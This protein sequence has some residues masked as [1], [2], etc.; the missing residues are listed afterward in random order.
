[1][2]YD[3][4]NRILLDALPFK[5]IVNF[6]VQLLFE[7]SKKH[8][9]TLMSDHKL[10]N[11]I[12]DHKLSQILD[13]TKYTSCE[14]YDE[15]KLIKH[16]KNN[17]NLNIFSM[18]I[19]S[20]PLH[21]GELVNYINILQTE[22]HVIVLT[23]IGAKNLSLV[24]NLFTSHHALQY[25][26]PLDN[27]RGGVGIFISSS[28]NDFEVLQNIKLTKN[29][30]CAE[31]QFESLFIDFEF[32]GHKYTVAGVYRHPKGNTTHFSIALEEAV[33]KCDNRRTT[34][35][36]ADSNIDL[37]KFN[38]SHVE[39][40]LTMMLNNK[41]LPYITLP[42]R[43]TE[44]S[45]T[46]IDHIFVRN[47]CDTVK[48]QLFLNMDSGLL[49]C[50]ISDHLPCFLSL[51]LK[52][53]KES[54][55]RPKVR[56]YGIK[57]TENFKNLMKDCNWNA[58]YENSSNWYDDFFKRI[59]S[60]HEKAFPLT[61]LSRKRSHDK[62]WV[63]RGLKISIT[64][65][66]RLYKKQL[67]SNS[68]SIVSKYKKYN[69]LLRKTLRNAET[70]YY[71]QLFEDK[72]S[73][74]T[75]TWKVLGP[76]INPSKYKKKIAIN[77]MKDNGKFFTE[78][79]E[80]VEIINQ[81]FCNIGKNLQQKIPSQNGISYRDYLPDHILNSF[82][83]QPLR[84]EDILLEIAKLNPKK[85]SGPDN[86]G[87][88]ILQ[89]CP[90]VFSYNLSIIFNH[91]IE[92]GEYPSALKLA[93]VIPIYK[94]GDHALPSNYRP[95]SLL[96]VFNKLFERM[97][98]R[99][100]LCFLER[101]EL[102]YCY[103][104]GYRKLHSTTLALIELT[105]SIRRLIDEKNIVFSLFIDFTKAF[106]TVDHQILLDKLTHY[107]V[108]GHT[109][110]FFKSYL[111]NRTQ[112]T[113][114]NG[115]TS[116]IQ[117]VTCGVPQGSVLGPILFLVYVNDLHRCLGNTM[118]RMFADDTNLTL[119]HERSDYLKEMSL[120]KI[121]ALMKWCECNKL[122]INWDKT[123]YI[124]FHAKN[125]KIGSYFNE[126]NVSGNTVKRVSCVKYLGIYID[127]L[128]TWRDHVS[129]VHKSLIRYYGIF[130][131][132]KNFIN[133]KVIRQLYFALV[134]SKIKYGIEL[135]GSCS[136][137]Q[138]HRIQ[139]I[140]S[141]LLKIILNLHRRTGTNQLHLNLRLLKVEHIYKMQLLLFINRCMLGKST[142]LFNSYFGY[143]D[144]QYRLRSRNLNPD[145]ARLQ[146][147]YLSVKNIASREWN[148]ISPSLKNKSNQLNFKKHIASYFISQ[149]G[150]T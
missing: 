72:Q 51:K 112:Y 76:L 145:F 17:V 122:T 132:I 91:Y 19:R 20:L 60:F 136:K 127:E 134:Y 103:Q 57:N 24:E 11:F 125:K 63:T 38:I 31:C 118:I 69:N 55:L 147:G 47:A 74:A 79:K 43:I 100:L 116:S 64:T 107:G 10:T 68:E 149:Y 9:M 42:S 30:S 150:E 22:F 41:F 148:R 18:N 113:A 75:N 77:K 35:Y 80:I 81:Y 33:Q 58:I 44:T 137:E 139:V 61:T 135:Y 110:D 5:D 4:N 96:S 26:S 34:F 14:Y 46:C 88:K 86:I 13:S 146:V 40:F 39:T 84:Q 37:I 87:N 70:R 126:M 124:V 2:S 123:Y 28:I 59:I 15:E 45:A 105:D 121:K 109:N 29:C 54:H 23:E 71:K 12:K 53:P 138:L 97:I 8:I 94:K 102:L 131:H 3:L 27:P 65:N 32:C 144:V 111:S 95:I 106:D 117:K 66:H 36:C 129:H 85:A 99:Q 50:D 141:G 73:A 143:R 120:T 98:C 52:N 114:V 104:Y 48:K 130:N 7:S 82:Y 56:L 128:L 142:T 119:F 89:I 6:E 1:M 62:P 78:K 25:V 90:E 93:K 133:K 101:H 83:L 92:K 49:F 67:T 16:V 108:R 115:E 140:Q 21:G